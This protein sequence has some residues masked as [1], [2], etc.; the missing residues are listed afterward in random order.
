MENTSK[1][2]KSKFR[3]PHEF[4]I[5]LALI[6]LACILTYVVPA[7]NYARVKTASGT[8][9]VDATSFA[10]VDSTPERFLKIP[11]EI[12]EGFYNARQLIFAIL[13]SV[14]FA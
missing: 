6:V 3:F 1:E 14:N 4:I 5:I 11:S 9:V 2:K 13:I 8:S 7:G 12:V 10:Y